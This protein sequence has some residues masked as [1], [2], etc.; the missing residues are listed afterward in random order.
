MHGL[1][2]ELLDALVV[3]LV[4]RAQEVLDEQRDRVDPF[5]ERGDVDGDDVQAV[6]EVLAELALSDRLLEVPVRR[7]DDPGIDSDVALPP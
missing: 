2:R 7:C 5:P 4:V 6:V 3:L 1:V